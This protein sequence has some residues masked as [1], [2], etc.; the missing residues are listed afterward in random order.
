MNEESA[1]YGW[2]SPFPEFEQ[3]QPK[4]VREKLNL[5]VKDAGRPQI[6]AWDDSIPPLQNEVKEIL[7]VDNLAAKYET[8]LEYQLPMESRRTDVI[9]LAG[10]AVVILE[11]KGKV[12]PSDADIDQVAAYAR[13][14]RCY[15][16]EC[17]ARPV[18]S[19]CVPMQARGRLG[20]EA[21]V[22]IAGPDVLDQ[23][24]EEIAQQGQK[25]LV[26]PDAF[27]ARDA[28]CPLP[29]LVQAARELFNSG[30]IRPI[31]RARAATDPAVEAITDLIHEAARIKT[32]K[33]IL[34]T[35]IPGAGKTLVGLRVVHAHFLDDLAV[36]RQ[37][38]KPTVP[39]VFLSG[40]GPLVQ[41]LQ[42][43]LKGSGGGGKT[44]VRNVKDYVRTYSQGK[45]LIPPE[46]VLVF[47]EAQRA[48]DAEQ[49]Q[50]KH[51]EMYKDFKS[52]PEHFIEFAERIPEWCVVIG[53]IGGG[54]EIH[55]GEE[56]GLIQW[57]HAI[58]NADQRNKWQVHAPEQVREPFQGSDVPLMIHA[59]LNLD[60]EI[61]F[62][63]AE[64]IHK[65][66]DDLLSG[67]PPNELKQLAEQ[68]LHAGYHLRIT[69]DLEQAKEYLRE[70]YNGVPEAR[71]GIIA[72]SRDKCLLGFGIDK[73]FR[74]RRRIQIGPWYSDDEDHPRMRS[75]RHLNDVITEFEAQGLELDAV[76]LAWG[77]DFIIKDGCWTNEFASRYSKKNR[78]RDPF[79]LRKNAYRVLLT[80]GRDA[81]IVY[82]PQ[83][84]QLDATAAYLQACGFRP[85]TQ[86]PVSKAKTERQGT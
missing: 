16:R 29:T 7:A 65:Y 9:F 60:Q 80:R 86:M 35:G 59:D 49:V 20:E 24:V 72:S 27:L 33:L 5:F 32:R 13:D 52:E 85:L 77:N 31:H 28:Y 25:Q 61:R 64:D 17:H 22:I 71:Y 66:V 69:R 47:D 43:E 34:L 40:N 82:L 46:H 68:L 55:V 75:C 38:G 19:I 6:R 62:H 78:V 63:L 50:A 57:R 30:T 1:G 11:L 41:V 4:E 18:V 56:A 83:S 74:T 45:Q 36:E 54:Q 70:R 21:G 26:N 44:F 73:E 2:A 15:H 12:L 37:H 23:I 14:L 10:G 76:L 84:D 8:I 53:L 39:A 51:G 48:F 3:A 42:Y 79:Q 58:E 81:T 67:A